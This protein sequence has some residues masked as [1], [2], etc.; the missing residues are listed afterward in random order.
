MSGT[1]LL[2]GSFVLER[3]PRQRNVARYREATGNSTG[4]TTLAS[5]ISGRR[6]AEKKGIRTWPSGSFLFFTQLLFTPKP[7]STQPNLHLFRPTSLLAHPQVISYPTNLPPVHQQC[8]SP[9]KLSPPSPSS[10]SVFSL[11]PPFLLRITPSPSDLSSVTG[12]VLPRTFATSPTTVLSASLGTTT[13]SPEL[14][15]E[16]L[17]H[18]TLDSGLSS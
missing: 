10:V 8:T 3:V 17:S 4:Q 6:N 12:G 13:P 1:R 15:V 16:D 9:L 14:G 18:P 7:Q 5:G 2:A 11:P